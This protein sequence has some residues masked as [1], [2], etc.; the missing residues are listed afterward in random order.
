M[1][2]VGKKRSQGEYNGNSY[3]NVVLHCECDFLG[4]NCEG[5]ETVIVKVKSSDC[6]FDSIPLGS[7]IQP[8]YNRFGKV[9][10][11]LVNK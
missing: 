8:I 9:D 6:S 4:D 11:I 1:I 5:S 7:D 3:D 2:V 10:R